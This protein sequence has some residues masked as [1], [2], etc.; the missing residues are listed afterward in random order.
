[1]DFN[2][3][4]AAEFFSVYSHKPP[5]IVKQRSDAGIVFCLAYRKGQFSVPLPKEILLMILNLAYTK[6]EIEAEKEAERKIM[7]EMVIT[8]H[9]INFLLITDGSATLRYTT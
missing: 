1:M 8:A 9:A 4:K 6:E 2:E 3:E 5:T 7:E